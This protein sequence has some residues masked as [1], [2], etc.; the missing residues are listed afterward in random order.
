LFPEEVRRT[1]PAGRTNDVE[2]AELQLRVYLVEDNGIVLAG[3][4]EALTELGNVEVVGSA[5]SSESA[6]IWLVEQRAHW[7]L[8]L[9]DLFLRGHSG[10]EV[11]RACRGR[12]AQSRVVVVTNYATDDIRQRCAALGADALF[13]KSTEIEALLAYVNR[14]AGPQAPGPLPGSC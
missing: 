4:T 5:A 2:R 8:A 9:V 11:I 6:S 1:D 3:L 7:D 13:D 10:L 12:A 14:M